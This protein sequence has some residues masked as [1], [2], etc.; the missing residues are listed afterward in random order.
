MGTPCP[1]TGK[2]AASARLLVRCPEPFGWPRDTFRI[3]SVSLS[4][5]GRAYGTGALSFL[6]YFLI[7]KK[8]LDIII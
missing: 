3:G 7:M 6:I 1:L 5:W 2:P 4:S 8:K